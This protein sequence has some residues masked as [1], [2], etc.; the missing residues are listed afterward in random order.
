MTGLTFIISAVITAYSSYSSAVEKPVYRTLL[1]NIRKVTFE[2]GKASQKIS[3]EAL[4]TAYPLN[5]N[6]LSKCRKL[7]PF[8]R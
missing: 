6:V 2:K 4:A 1:H 3:S 7:T 5:I 8:L